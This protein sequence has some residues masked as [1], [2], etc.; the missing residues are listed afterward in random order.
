[1]AEENEA[2]VQQTQEAEETN[3]EE[4]GS[5]QET[6]E[7]TEET[8]EQ[9]EKTFT[10]SELDEIISK[11]IERERSK[12]SDYDD[13]RKKAEEYEKEAEERRLAEMSEK[14]RAEEEAK[15]HEQEKEEY[16]QQLESY[17]TQVEQEKISN[18]F[19]KQAQA[20]NIAYVDDALALADLSAVTVE[21]GKVS[22][23]DD[24]V[25]SLIENKPFL[26]AQQKQKRSVGEPTNNGGERATD[27]TAEQAWKEAED[28][29]KKTG[30]IEDRM[31]A[32]K[33]KREAK[34]Q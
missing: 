28:K 32:A 2:N 27:K 13:I 6:S 22:G 19:I 5:A 33:L 1:M 34:R 26:L 11:R 8:S 9:A 21:E 15:K 18:E 24:V 23:V 4:E 25:N 30:R 17:K 16:R 14:E 29:A 20:A 12:Y 31:E 10:Q 3:V 7:T